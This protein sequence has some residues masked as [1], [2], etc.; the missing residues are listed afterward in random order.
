VR[1]RWLDTGATVVVTGDAGA[2]SAA[3]GPAGIAVEA[4]RDRRHRYWHG[5]KFLGESGL[6]AL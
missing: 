1:Q 6:S 2:V 5:P 4:E 3:L